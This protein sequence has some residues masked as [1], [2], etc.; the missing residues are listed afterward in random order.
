MA[1]AARTVTFVVFLYILC[2]PTPTQR[3]PA[4]LIKKNKK[5]LEKAQRYSQDIHSKKLPA[6]SAELIDSRLRE[7]CDVVY[8]RD[9]VLQ[10]HCTVLYMYV[11]RMGIFDLNL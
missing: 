6:E 11:C 9:P 7:K 4:T 8:W 10:Y 2:R 3:G 5:K 1:Q